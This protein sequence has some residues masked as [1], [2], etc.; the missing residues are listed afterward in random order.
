VAVLHPTCS[1]SRAGRGQRLV[2]LAHAVADEVVVPDSWG[3]CGFAGDRGLLVPE[4]TAS[5]TRA[6][7]VEIESR[8]YDAYLSDNR[9]CE[10][11]MS[12]ATAKPFRHV[13]ELL[14]E[15]TR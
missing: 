13:V 6:E 7:A 11:G 12:R 14:E 10:I 9:T 2:E 1:T 3:C 5:A 15:L 8:E 4:L